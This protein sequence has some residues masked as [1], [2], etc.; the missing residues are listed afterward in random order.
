MS[1]LVG[2]GGLNPKGKEALRLNAMI[3][4]GGIHY[5]TD[6]TPYLSVFSRAELDVLTVFKRDTMMNLD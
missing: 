5:Q 1:P 6:H 4:G 3:Y 2:I